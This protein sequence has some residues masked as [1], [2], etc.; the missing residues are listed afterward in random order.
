[1]VDEYDKPLL[2]V[3]DNEPLLA[4]FRNILKGFYSNL[5]TCDEHIRFAFLTGVTKFSHV[6]IF[7]DLNRS[8]M[9]TRTFAASPRRKSGRLSPL[10]YRNSRN[11]SRWMRMR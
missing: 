11:R 1:M 7:S 9:H 4:E 8:T 5:K 10:I 3:I 2:Q 6:S